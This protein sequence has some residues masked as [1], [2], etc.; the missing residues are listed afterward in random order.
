MEAAVVMRKFRGFDYEDRS[1]VVDA[2]EYRCGDCGRVSFGSELAPV[3]YREYENPN[4]RIEDDDSE[5]F[6]FVCANKRCEYCRG[7]VVP[8]EPTAAGLCI[9]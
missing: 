2:A 5:K 9:A 1:G 3:L 6:V 8:I 4:H 7:K